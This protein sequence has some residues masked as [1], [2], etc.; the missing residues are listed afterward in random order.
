[1]KDKDGLKKDRKPGT[2]MTMMIM[3]VRSSMVVELTGRI[4]DISW[5]MTMMRRSKRGQADSSQ[6]G[7]VLGRLLKVGRDPLG[8]EESLTMSTARRR[9]NRS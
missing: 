9:F 4:V 1:M 5:K 2:M 6:R 8:N 3:E 7:P